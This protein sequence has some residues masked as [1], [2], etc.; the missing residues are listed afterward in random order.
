[1]RRLSAR[2]LESADVVFVHDPQPAPLLRYCPGVPGKW[3][4][5]CHIDVSRPYRPV[6]KYLRQFV[7]A[8][9]AS[10]FSI[11]PFAQRMPHPVFLI[12]PSI[13]PLSEK[14]IV[15]PSRRGPQPFWTTSA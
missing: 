15:L 3:V 8:Y 1:M 10:V 2:P 13:D 4:W 14:N 5:R 7:A 12:P 11:A 6:W 9:D